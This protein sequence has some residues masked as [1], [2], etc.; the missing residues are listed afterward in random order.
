MN[1]QYEQ[2]IKK[3]D[4]KDT[5]FVLRYAVIHVI[6]MFIFNRMLSMPDV[7]GVRGIMYLEVQTI[8]LLA[9]FAIANI[10]IICT[11]VVVKKQGLASVGIH[12]QQLWSA[13]RLSFLFAL[14]P[15]VFAGVLPGLLN[16][17]EL[18]PV[19]RISLLLGFFI[20]MAATEDVMIV[21]FIQTRLYGR[22]GSDRVAISVGALIFAAMH[23]PARLLPIGSG[24]PSI[25]FVAIAFSFGG[26]FIAHWVYVTLFKKYFSI[27]TVTI[28][29]ALANFSQTFIWIIPEDANSYGGVAVIIVWIAVGIWAW[30]LRRKTKKATVAA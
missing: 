19:G 7:E 29:H 24:T 14:I 12:K 25:G 15:L 27:F 21:G 13:L 11:I 20:I 10:A 26:W 4:P 28:V 22:Y 3:Y 2:E 9:L 6:A 1:P 17:W 30:L 8:L 23:L 18:A 16:G 5:K